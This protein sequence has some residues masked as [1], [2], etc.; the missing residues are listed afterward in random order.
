MLRKIGAPGRREGG[1]RSGGAP[2]GALGL[3]LEGED[4]PPTDTMA[5]R[6]EAVRCASSPYVGRRA[7]PV[8][9]CRMTDGL[10]TCCEGR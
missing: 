3:V 2:E 6:C 8:V 7:R 9:E 1:A 4:G 5:T 10:W